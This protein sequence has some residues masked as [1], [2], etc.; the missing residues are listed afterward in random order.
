MSWRSVCESSFP[1]LVSYL[2]L[3]SGALVLLC[4]V[5][6]SKKFIFRSIVRNLRK[7]KK[8]GMKVM[9]GGFGVIILYF[10]LSIGG[11]CSTVFVWLSDFFP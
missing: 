4:T 1:Q 9:K 8:M 7:I 10:V 6:P 2:E 11:I 3:G 5:R